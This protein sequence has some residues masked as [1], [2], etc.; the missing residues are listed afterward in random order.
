[1]SHESKQ[2]HH[3]ISMNDQWFSAVTIHVFVIVELSVILHLNITLVPRHKSAD[4]GANFGEI[5]IESSHDPA[6]TFALY[7]SE[8]W[9]SW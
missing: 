9:A 3:L 8:S 7:G 6:S 4:L 5:A 1:M 2:D